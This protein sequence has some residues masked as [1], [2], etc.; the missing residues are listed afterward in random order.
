MSSAQGGVNSFWTMIRQIVLGGMFLVCLLL[1]ILWRVDSPRVDRFRMAVSDAL[2]PSIEWTAKPFASFWRMVDDFQSYARVY[3][4][5]RELRRELQD[6]KGWREAALQLEQK[7]ARLRALNN[8]RIN[9]QLTFI[10][11]EVMTDTGGPFSQSGLINV[12]AR[13]GIRDGAAAL[14][15]LGL[16]GR[17]SGVGTATARVIYL[18]DI[19][20]RVPIIIQPSGQRGIVSGDNT[21]AP[22]LDFVEDTE[23]VNPG[24]RV[25]TSGDGDVL[26]PD[27]LVGQVIQTPDGRFRILPAA[28]YQR[29]EFLRVLEYAPPPPVAETGALITRSLPAEG[30]IE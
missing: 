25:V 16:V 22:R 5:N 1:F 9:P 14:D 11:G 12:G 17:I 21:R 26:P 24:D 27:I 8:V 30:G 13:N 19:N 3:E 18:T 15:G 29:L 28:D 4:Q 10:T 2:M 6:M 7:N 20:S 23:R